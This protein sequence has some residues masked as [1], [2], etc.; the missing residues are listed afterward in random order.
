[1]LGEEHPAAVYAPGEHNVL[2]AVCAYAVGRQLRLKTEEII[3]GIASY[4]PYG[5]RQNII[6]A[7]GYTIFADCYNSSLI[8]IGNTLAAMDDIVLP[9]GGRK[10]AVL[11]DI[12]A[13]GDIAEET[14]RQIAE[15]IL[16]HDVDIVL[17]YG[18]NIELTIEE[19]VHTT[20]GPVAK[21]FADR[22]EAAPAPTSN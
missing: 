3:D 10:I 7:D 11:G 18:I 16:E 2:N 19:L 13:L 1:M 8:A 12:L 4:S 20:G 9:E 6:K 17:G 14:H 5:L 15:V 21:F 22:G